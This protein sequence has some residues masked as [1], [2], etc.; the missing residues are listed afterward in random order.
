M[1]FKHEEKTWQNLLREKRATREYI[2]QEAADTH[3]PL[4]TLS[5]HEYGA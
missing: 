4:K 5:L 3:L 1:K 2:I